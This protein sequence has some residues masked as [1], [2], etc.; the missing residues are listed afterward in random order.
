MYRRNVDDIS[1]EPVFRTVVKPSVEDINGVW[2]EPALAGASAA[3]SSRARHRAWLAEQWSRAADRDNLGVFLFLCAF[4]GLAAILCTVLK[5]TFGEGI[6]TVAVAAPV[7]EEMSKVAMPLMVLEK[8]PWQFG[9]YSTIVLVGVLSGAVF[10]SV[11]NLLYFFVYI[12]QNKLTTGII[13]WRLLVCTTLHVGCA[14]L[15]CVGLARAWSSARAKRDAFTMS[16]AMP[17]LIAAMAIHGIYNFGAV[18]YS[19][20]RP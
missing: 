5:G 11:E 1:N 2:G 16:A 15:S 12:P 10:A 4:S 8:R 13:L 7:A 18:L 19:F 9:A 20:L 17:W 3:D 14:A 6:L